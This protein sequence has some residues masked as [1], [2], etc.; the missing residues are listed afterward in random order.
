MLVTN[1]KVAI[2]H[3]IARAEPAPA[4]IASGGERPI[5]DPQ[6]AILCHRIERSHLA[7][8]HLTQRDMAAQNYGPQIGRREHRTPKL[9]KNWNS[10]V[11]G[12]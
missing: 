5:L 8:S 12:D 2:A 3:Y 6:A 1:G 10:Q 9:T 4:F 7:D 11:R